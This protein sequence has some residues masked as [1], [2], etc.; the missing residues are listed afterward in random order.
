MTDV[1]TR[2]G[3]NTQRYTRGRDHMRME[4]G[5]RVSMRLQ[6]K[7]L[8]PVAASN[9]RR[10]EDRQGTSCASEPPEGTN[11]ANTLISDFWPPEPGESKF[12]LFETT[13]VVVAY[14]GSHRK[15]IQL[16]MA[17][18]HGERSNGQDK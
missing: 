6:A 9:H 1:L 7:E 12:L 17:S 15:L 4:A 3:D 14:Y 13:Q 8:I 10:L 5:T 16:L 11:A 2:R 18:T